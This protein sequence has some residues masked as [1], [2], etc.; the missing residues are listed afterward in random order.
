MTTLQAAVPAYAIGILRNVDLGP[1]ITQY[2]ER[3]DGTLEPFGG[4]FVVHGGAT[5][6][7]EGA[8]PGDIVVIEF[9]DR[10]HAV[11]WYRSP[12]Y[13]AILPLRADNAD[14]TVVIV[15]GVPPDHAATDVLGGIEAHR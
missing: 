8:H 11:A 13:Q 4:R 15:D 10:Q 14:S 5:D 1:A 12:A 7:L 2:L 9:P 6:T 3:I